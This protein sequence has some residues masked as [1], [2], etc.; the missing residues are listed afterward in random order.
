MTLESILETI[1]F[2]HGEPVGI[3]KLADLSGESPE[4]VKKTLDELAKS[5]AGRGIVL[6]QKDDQYHLGSHPD[7]TA[8]V[9]AMVRSEFSEALSRVALETIAI[10]AYKGPLARAEIEYIRGVNS[11]FTLRNLMMRGLIEREEDLHESRA[12]RYRVSSGLLNYLGL[13]NMDDLPEYSLL[14]ATA[15]QTEVSQSP[16]P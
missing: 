13:T 8:Y 11:S 6:V 2:V 4:A 5:Y 3:K 1:L 16:K 12:Y 14:H 10:I 7:N 15:I 9:S